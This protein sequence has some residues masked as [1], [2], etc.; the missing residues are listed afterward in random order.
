M[1]ISCIIKFIHLYPNIM[2]VNKE[3]FIEGF[4]FL[5]NDSDLSIR[6]RAVSAFLLLTENRLADLKP[7][8]VRVINFI[9][10]CM[11]HSNE[12]LVLEAAEFWNYLVEYPDICEEIIEPLLPKIFPIILS[13]MIYTQQDLLDL[14]DEDDDADKPDK[15]QNI[16]PTV[17]SY[18]NR[19]NDD[20]DDDNTDYDYHTHWNMRKA[21]AE[22]MERLA[23][24]FEE[25]S[26]PILLPLFELGFQ[27]PS[28][29][30]RESCILGLGCI[31]TGCSKDM[32]PYLPKLVPYLFNLLSDEK[33]LMRAITC[34]TLSRYSGW[35]SREKTQLHQLVTLLLQRMQDR[36]KRVQKSA[37]SAIAQVIDTANKSDIM[38]YMESILKSFNIAFMTFQKDN[39]IVLYDA[40]STVA[41]NLNEN[42]NE[43][44]YKDLLLSP[45]LQKWQT[46][47]DNDPDLFPLLE[48]LSFVSIAVGSEF[49]KY[50]KPVFDRCSRLIEMVINGT[51]LH[52][53]DTRNELPSR[54]FLICSL[55]MIS[56]LCEA[57]K[58]AIEPFVSDKKFL[59]MI[60]AICNDPAPDYSQSVFAL[61]GDISKYAM[62]VFT[63]IFNSLMPLL[64]NGVRSRF[65]EASNNAIWAIG[66]ITA[67]VPQQVGPYADKIHE[68]VVAV[69]INQNDNRILETCAVT[70]GRLSMHYPN[71][72]AANL[73]RLFAPLCKTLKTLGDE[74]DKFDALRGICVAVRNNPGDIIE[75]FDMFCDTLT[76]LYQPPSDLENMFRFLLQSF[77][78]SIRQEEWNEKMESLR[79]ATRNTLQQKYNI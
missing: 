60:L 7:Y 40:I 55:D 18:S 62:R 71:L 59:H 11:Q 36:N 9:L 15:P 57:V 67:Q 33:P 66:E 56:A 54:E 17:S 10:E 8:L 4:F 70:L 16:R 38:P 48:C 46:L 32:I 73:K 27:N 72:L 14:E 53:Q 41:E 19:N 43:G 78:N 37:T 29:L 21:A 64:L 25:K 65:F 49:L 30:I 76:G 22:A 79:P 24:L 2:A 52:Y 58:E 42:I 77:K 39:M 74:R 28:W 68:S 20:D 26:L 31:S 23:A 47:H 50:T 61:V 75:E 44:N 51:L 45:L 13:R 63:P 69:F 1:A 34:W 6:Q 5:A 12:D 3:Q 35:I